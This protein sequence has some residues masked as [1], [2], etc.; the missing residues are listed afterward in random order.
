MIYII[1]PIH[2]EALTVR[3]TANELV[4][5]CHATLENYQILFIND[6]S[7]DTT[8]PVLEKIGYD[9]C[10]ILNNS[11]AK[12]KGS[13]LK[14]AFITA[15]VFYKIKDNDLI[16]FMDGDGQI[17]LFNIENFLT[18]INAEGIDGVIGNKRHRFSEI[19]YPLVR[20]FIS[21]SYNLLIRILF[22]L[23]H[24]DTQCGLKLF[25]GYVLKNLIDKLT[26]NEFA[27]D[28]ELLLLA[29]CH[30]YFIIDAP[31]IL[32]SQ[33]NMGSVSFRNI[34]K[35][36]NDTIRIWKNYKKGIYNINKI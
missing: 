23:P 31:I 28:L 6:H 26:I 19:N 5:Y 4:N 12:G 7:T 25:R 10:K 21:Q 22:N 33:S 24:K 30:N 8:V 32:K 14:N 27:F 36:F 20:K 2:N 35:T 3:S 9:K 16:F 34:I 29:K 18:Y 17:A 15:N 11:C 1:L 13:A